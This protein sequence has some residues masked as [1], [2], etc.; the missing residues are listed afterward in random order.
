MSWRR[1]HQYLRA[2]NPLKLFIINEKLSAL[3][4]PSCLNF[5]VVCDYFVISL[6]NNDYYNTSSSLLHTVWH[7]VSPTNFSQCVVSARANDSFGGATDPPSSQ[8][9]IVIMQLKFCTVILFV[10]QGLQSVSTSLE[11]GQLVLPRWHSRQPCR[12]SSIFWAATVVDIHIFNSSM[13]NPCVYLR[14]PSFRYPPL[15][16]S[17]YPHI[18][19]F[20]HSFIN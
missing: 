7:R 2:T 13:T 14:M 16:S 3:C 15:H 5:D 18:H 20:I 1:G 6:H 8:K 19:P 11:D 9:P 4:A 10:L 12:P 17:I